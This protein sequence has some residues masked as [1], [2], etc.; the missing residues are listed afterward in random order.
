M[1]ESPG[2]LSAQL[3]TCD[4]LHVIVDCVPVWTRRGLAEMDAVGALTSTE[5]NDGA[6]F[7]PAPEQT[8]W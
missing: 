3:F 4:A 5:A 1:E 6:E 7:P 8:T 2:P